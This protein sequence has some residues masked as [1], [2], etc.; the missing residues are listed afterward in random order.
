MALSDNQKL[1]AIYTVL[2]GVPGTDAGGAVKSIENIETHLNELNG[3]VKV[4]TIW[5]RVFAWTIGTIFTCMTLLI[6][7]LWP[8]FFRL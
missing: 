5:R 7:Y 8:L 1:D 2:L 6:A 4:N 3:A